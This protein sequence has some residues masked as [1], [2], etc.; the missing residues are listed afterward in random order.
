MKVQL[1]KSALFFVLS[2]V[3]SYQSQG[4]EKRVVSVDS[5]AAFID[6]DTSLELIETVDTVYHFRGDK[7]QIPGKLELYRDKNTG[8]VVKVK[9]NFEDKHC[10]NVT[11]YLQ[12]RKALKIIIKEKVRRTDINP[13]YETNAVVYF[14][15]DNLITVNHP[16]KELVSNAKVYLI[17]FYNFMNYQ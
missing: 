16:K 10:R 15:D 17:Q 3:I 8:N 14:D 12:N 5:I 6:G 1:R 9:W 11:L 2:L 7:Y 13:E 4:Q